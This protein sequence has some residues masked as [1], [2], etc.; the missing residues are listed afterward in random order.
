MRP[1]LITTFGLCAL[2]LVAACGGGDGGETGSISAAQADSPKEYV[3]VYESELTKI[4]DAVESVTDEASARQAAE[5]IQAAS[6]ELEQL[7][8]KLETMTTMDKASFAINFSA[9]AAD[10]QM[11]LA[12]AMQKLAMADPE[13]MRMISEAMD[14]LPEPELGN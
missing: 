8:T 14:E 9:D 11:R 2:G 7:S 5:I 1:I 12:T 3:A 13:H 4:A 10:T 6:G